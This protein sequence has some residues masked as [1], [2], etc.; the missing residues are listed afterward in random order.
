MEEFFN[1]LSRLNIKPKKFKKD[2]G[3]LKILKHKKDIIYFDFGPPPPSRFSQYYQSGPLSFEYFY[4][5][6]KII[7][8]S[9]FGKDLNSKNKLYSRLTSAQSTICINET[10]VVKFQKKK[11]VSDDTNFII[12][13]KFKIINQNFIDNEE[14]LKIEASHNAYLK[15]YNCWV[16]REIILN[17]KTDSLN[18]ID[19]IK[20]ENHLSKVSYAIRFHLYPG[21]NVVKTIGRESALIQINKNKSLIF[22]AKGQEL[23]I[24]KS[25]FFGR[26]KMLNSFCINIMSTLETNYKKIYWE[27]KKNI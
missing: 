11:F 9:G 14:E 2:V 4:D 25:V 20:R 15:K 6:E 8:N 17:K 27:I 1:Y 21:I 13:E 19:E 22:L 23:N 16:K 7:T 10:S 24:E 26:N 12:D 3:F 5:G 18:G